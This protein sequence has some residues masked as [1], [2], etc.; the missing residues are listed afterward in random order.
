M[1]FGRAANV[2]RWT[3]DGKGKKTPELKS[4]GVFASAPTYRRFSVPRRDRDHS[5]QIVRAV[6]CVRLGNAIKPN[7]RDLSG[8]NAAETADRSEF[9]IIQVDRRIRIG[10]TPVQAGLATI[11]QKICP[12]LVNHVVRV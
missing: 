11:G 12:Q 3:W 5:A 8:G 4:P 6:F 2:W 10:L 7:H 1:N 9:L